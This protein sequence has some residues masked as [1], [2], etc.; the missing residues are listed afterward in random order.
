MSSVWHGDHTGAS[1]RVRDDGHVRRPWANGALR[2]LRDRAPTFRC[3]HHRASARRAPSEGL[4]P[5]QRHLSLH[6]HQH[7]RDYRLEELLACHY[8]HRPRYE[9]NKQQLVSSLDVPL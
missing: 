3:W 2:V 1:D 4:R 6:R 8:Q 7:L 9:P 5:R